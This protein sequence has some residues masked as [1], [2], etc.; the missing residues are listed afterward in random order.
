MDPLLVRSGREKGPLFAKLQIIGGAHRWKG[1]CQLG[2]KKIPV[3][4]LGRMSDEKAKV[5]TDVLN[6]TR[7][8]NDPLKWIEMVESVRDV[9]PELLELL[10]YKPEELNALLESG[11]VDWGELD[12]QNA[13]PHQNQQVDSQG[14]LY[15]KFTV[16]IPEATMAKVQDLMRKI[17]AA[18]KFDNDALA[19]EV[20]LDLAAKGINTA[21]TSVPPPAPPKRRKTAA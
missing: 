10:P 1:A 19:F 9:A 20:L 18:H 15:K 3:R 6:N 21:R 7:G 5:L 17:K 8:E 11:R 14:K 16:S 4:D 2:M 12:E 13:T